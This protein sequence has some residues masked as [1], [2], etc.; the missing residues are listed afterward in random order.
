MVLRLLI[1]HAICH[2][3]FAIS[4]LYSYFETCC[5]HTRTSCL[6]SEIGDNRC[7]VCSNVTYCMD[8][9]FQGIN[10]YIFWINSHNFRCSLLAIY[11]LILVVVAMCA[12]M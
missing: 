11:L 12:C 8:P 7:T 2:L 5:T 9:I 4:Y 3:S 1:H 6:E 10:L